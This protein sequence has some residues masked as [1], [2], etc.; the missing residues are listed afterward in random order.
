MYQR[1]NIEN[2]LTE[3]VAEEELKLIEEARKEKS[4]SKEEFLDKA[5]K[6]V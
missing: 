2:N 3:D 6:L 4:I 5:K 1:R